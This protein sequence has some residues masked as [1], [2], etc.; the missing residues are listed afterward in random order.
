[1]L[2]TIIVCALLYVVDGDTV[3]CDG[4]NMRLLGEGIVG[5]RGVDTPELRAWKCEKERKLAKARLKK[6][7]PAGL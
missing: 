6:R 4:Q 5:V 2:A 7:L 3:K 1:M